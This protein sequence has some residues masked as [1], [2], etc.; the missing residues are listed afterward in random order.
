MKTKYATL[1]S[2]L[3]VVNIFNILSSKKEYDVV[4]YGGTSAGISSAIQ[5]SRMN[6]TVLL[7]EPTNRIGGLTTGGLGATDIGSKNSIGGI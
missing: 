1:L 4:I 5:C 3:L 7:I 6:K 2:F